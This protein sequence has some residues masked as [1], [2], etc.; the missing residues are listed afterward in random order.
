[1]NCVLTP[2]QRGDAPQAETLLADFAPGQVEF[3]VA[4][5]AYDSDAIR[6]RIKR[7]QA[8]ACIRP[9]PTRKIKKR[10]DRRRYKG[11]NVIERVFR[12]LKE[13]RRIAT[14]YEKKARNFIGFL[15]LAE[16]IT[17]VR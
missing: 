7:L 8:K 10:Y 2:G 5:A 15:W 16:F 14:R 17:F 3:V 12:R 9:N 11:R 13:C 4:D 6:R 1:M